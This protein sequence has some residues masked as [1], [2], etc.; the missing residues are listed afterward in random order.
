MRNNDLE[1]TSSFVSSSDHTNTIEMTQSYSDI[2]KT[3][4][5]SGVINIPTNNQQ[6]SSDSGSD[7]DSDSSSGSSSGSSSD[8]ESDHDSTLKEIT[9]ENS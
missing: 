7:S 5:D 2:N 4:N 6:L 9:E 1:V 8:S 3:I